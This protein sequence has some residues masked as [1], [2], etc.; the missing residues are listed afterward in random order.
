MKKLLALWVMILVLS[1]PGYSA[2]AAPQHGSTSP[3]KPH[4][5]TADD[6]V[7]PNL[8]GKVVETM[9]AAGYTYVLLENKGKK[10]W[11]AVAEM[12][13][14]VG[15]EMA[16]LPGAPMSQFTS[17]SL[18]RTF[19]LIYFSSGV[20]NTVSAGKTVSGVSPGSK[21]S[22]PE[23]DKGVKVEKAAGANAYTVA[24]IYQKAGALNKKTVIVKG[25]VVKVSA[26]IMK[27]N[28]IHIQDGTGDPKNGSNNLVVTSDDLP[29]KGD[30]VTVKGILTK[31]KDFGSGY[32]YSVIMEKGSVQ[33]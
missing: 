13:V 24:E 2:Y 6:S 28:W 11:V 21:A 7:E 12:K 8:S 27:M 31:D 22:V 18:N 3:T 15:D 29:A 19:D 4:T 30:I 14:A 20:V 10:T 26:G 5:I 9:S 23:A 1:L 25:K 17:K 16:F 33:K 32:K